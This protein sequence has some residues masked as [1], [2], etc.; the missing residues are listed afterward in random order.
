MNAP[1]KPAGFS[2]MKPSAA[3]AKAAA[4]QSDALNKA[5]RAYSV[6]CANKGVSA[7]RR[8]P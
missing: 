2:F 4:M 1:T 3:A 6:Q 8:K 7:D 5:A